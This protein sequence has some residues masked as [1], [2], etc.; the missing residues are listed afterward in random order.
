MRKLI[1]ANTEARAVMAG[2]DVLLEKAIVALEGGAKVTDTLRYSSADLQRQVHQDAMERIMSAR[3]ELRLEVVDACV[4]AGFPRG[5]IAEW[6]G[7]SRQRVDQMVQAGRRRG[8]C[9]TTT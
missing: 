9:L 7:I 5:T 1:L 6:W 8:A 2:G 4:A 3:R